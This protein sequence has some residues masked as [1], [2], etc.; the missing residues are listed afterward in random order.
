MKPDLRDVF[1]FGGLILLA[2]GA[3]LWVEPATGL[4]VLG[5]GLFTLG[6][7]GGK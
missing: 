6:I 3:G 7:R 4:V 2:I 1:V 5:L